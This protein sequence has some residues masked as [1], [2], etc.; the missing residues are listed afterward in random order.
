M[1]V[2]ILDFVDREHRLQ[3]LLY[4]LLDMEAEHI[5]GYVGVIEQPVEDRLVAFGLSHKQQRQLV[6][7]RTR[8]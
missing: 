1:R 6:R 8:Q 2:L 3:A 4:R 5:V 7:L